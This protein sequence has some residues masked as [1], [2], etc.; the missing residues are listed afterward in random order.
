MISWIKAH[1]G[2]AL[3]ALGGLLTA[4]FLLANWR[5]KRRPA[6][7]GLE[8]ARAAGEA[9]VKAADAQVVAERAN[10]LAQTLPEREAALEVIRTTP[11]PKEVQHASDDD[12]ARLFSRS[13]L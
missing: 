9:D 6:P 11:T 3:A 8:A 13:G 10:K 12:V 2:A 7:E 4:V 5:R 1:W